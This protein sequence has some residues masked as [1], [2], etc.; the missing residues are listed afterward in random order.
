MLPE[1]VVAAM[2]V[3]DGVD[4]VDQ[5]GGVVGVVVVVVVV[6]GLRRLVTCRRGLAGIAW[7]CRRR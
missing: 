6:S 5:G 2:V 3:E 7:F 1:S 4:V